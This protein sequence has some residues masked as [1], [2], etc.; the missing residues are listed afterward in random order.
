MVGEL[1]EDMSLSRLVTIR[2]VHSVISVDISV[3][4]VGEKESRL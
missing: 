2:I 4:E 3:T 1:Q